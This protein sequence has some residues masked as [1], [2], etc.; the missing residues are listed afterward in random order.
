M[1]A[2]A[3]HM[4]CLLTWRW[5]LS[6]EYELRWHL[7]RMQ[8]VMHTHM[9]TDGSAERRRRCVCYGD[10]LFAWSRQLPCWWCCAL[11]GRNDAINVPSGLRQQDVC[12]D[13]GGAERW[14][15]V[16]AC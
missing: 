7:E 11:C 14:H 12:G 8:C 5:R 2:Y 1:P 3:W 15:C 6:S 13:A 4:G 16:P 9:D 10:E